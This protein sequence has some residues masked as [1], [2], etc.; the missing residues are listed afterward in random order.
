MF[1]L[2]NPFFQLLISLLNLN[3]FDFFF[4][5]LDTCLRQI[6]KLLKCQSE[7]FSVREHEK[8][9]VVFPT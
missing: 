9:K 3:R 2:E 8:Q 6:Y 7:Q 5:M 4:P 1:P